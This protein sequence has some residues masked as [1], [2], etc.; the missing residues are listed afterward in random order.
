[1]W[2]MFIRKDGKPAHVSP[3]KLFTEKFPLPVP[4]ITA[5]QMLA[6]E[7]LK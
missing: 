5:A 2:G 4:V 3:I 6:C 7:K 1:M